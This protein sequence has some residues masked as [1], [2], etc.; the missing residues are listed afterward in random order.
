MF[1]N[2]DIPENDKIILNKLGKNADTSISELLAFTKYK[3]KSSVYNRIRNLR[4]EEYL[5][6]PYFDINY[7]AIGANK[8]FSVFVLA[9]YN[10]QFKDLVLEA[11][12]KINCWTM[13]YPVRTAESYLGIYQCNNWN[14]TASLFSLMR[15]W[16]WLK[17][18]SVHK[19]E[20]R[21]L[22]QNP[23]FFGDFLPSEDYQIPE[24]ELPPYKYED[25]NIDFEFTKTDL[26]IIKHLSRQTCH[27]TRIRDLEYHYYGLR[28]KYHDLKRSYEKL[29]KSGILIKKNYLMLPLPADMCSLFFLFSK[30][31]NFRSHL[32]MIACFG[33]D[34]R[35]TKVFVA[36]GKGVISYFL[37]HP[38]LEVK[39]L[40][41]L[42]NDDTY[43]N[44]YGI[45][46]YPSTE[47]SVQT[48]N[49]DYFDVDSQRWVFP[50]SEF[51]EEIKELK[52]KKEKRGISVS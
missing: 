31:K 35:L 37:A 33:K 26:I 23:N 24:G 43:A 34:L 3:R 6:G 10:L 27:L 11:M 2:K 36:V 14:Y 47:F 7:N 51:K 1:I 13:I 20:Y 30:G 40:G 41:M 16:G 46:S 25:L 4:E 42:E 17:G 49:D 28:L 5:F 50:Y 52:E 38:L 22:I 39:I 45:K 29:E 15:K 9:D 44:I 19:S 18:F 12:K 48:F 8:L 32:K 21:R